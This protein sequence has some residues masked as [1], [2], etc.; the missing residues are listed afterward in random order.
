[1]TGKARNKLMPVVKRIM[2]Y[3]QVFRVRLYFEYNLFR[4]HRSCE[5]SVLCHLS[6]MRSTLKCIGS[7]Q[8][9]CAVCQRFVWLCRS[10]H[11]ALSLTNSQHD[12]LYLKVH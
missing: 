3:Q 9:N 10:R 8:K 11:T 6:N 5:C 4:D 7:F 12:V 1:M 2:P